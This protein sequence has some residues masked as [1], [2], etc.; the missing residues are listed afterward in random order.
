[1]T[2]V[3]FTKGHGTQN[4][5]VLVPDLDGIRPLTTTEVRLLADR[6]AGLGGDG[7]IRVVATARAEEA[8]VRQQAGEAPWFM[9]YH[10]ADGSPAEMCGNGARCFA[11]FA[12]RTAGPLEKISFET[13]AGLIGA[14]LRGDLVRLEMSR[15][16]DL[17]IGLEVPVG[18]KTLSAH[19]IDSGVPH[20][21]VPDQLRSAVSGPHRYDPEINQTYA[22]LAQHYGFAPIPARPRKPRDKRTVN[23][24]SA[25]LKHRISPTRVNFFPV[26][27]PGQ[28]NPAGA[29]ILP[30][31]AE[32]TTG[33]L[34]TQVHSPMRPS[35]PLP[36]QDAR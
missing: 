13:P 16:N 21:V 22:E 15:P 29:S 1:M 32:S 36:I 7:V 6:H 18:D 25:L 14:E 35:R 9:D 34:S 11:R 20:V 4:D 19:Y 28:P 2:T 26:L 33:L 3:P 8:E 10:N 17:R 31:E 5:F 12:N 30:L 23:G 24:L 27:R